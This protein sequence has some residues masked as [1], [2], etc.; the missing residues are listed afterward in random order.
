MEEPDLEGSL[1]LEKLAEQGQ[2]EAFF[3]AVNA[4]GSH[5]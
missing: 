4:D 5:S 3:E 2:T 1:V